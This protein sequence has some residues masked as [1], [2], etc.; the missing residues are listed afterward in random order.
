M[1]LMIVA[2]AQSLTISKPATT[3]ESKQVP[4][5]AI[6]SVNLMSGLDALSTLFLITNNYSTE[7]NPV[8]NAL[9]QRSPLLFFAIKMCITVG[10]TLVCWH[11]YERKQRARKILRLTSRFYCGLMAWHCLLLSSVLL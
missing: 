10:A 11:Y 5:M 6:I 7:M 1:G 8:M 2:V 3:T 4:M 9:I